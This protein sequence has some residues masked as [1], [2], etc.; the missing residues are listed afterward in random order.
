MESNEKIFSCM[1]HIDMAMDEYI[2]EHE[3]SPDLMESHKEKCS[4]CDE[5][6]KYEVK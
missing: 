2:T 5:P 1:E 4:F 3:K 6:S